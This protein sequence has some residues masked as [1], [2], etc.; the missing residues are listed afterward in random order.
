M[1][2]QLPLNKQALH[3]KGGV[4]IVLDKHKRAPPSFSVLWHISPPP[5]YSC[6]YSHTPTPPPPPFI[7]NQFI[8]LFSPPSNPL[9]INQTQPSQVW[10]FSRS[11]LFAAA[12]R[13]ESMNAR[14]PLINHTRP[15]V[16]L[17]SVTSGVVFRRRRHVSRWDLGGASSIMTLISFFLYTD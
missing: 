14:T 10:P 12:G 1:L 6:C 17:S 8:I 13:R 2:D 7:V 3:T 11:L 5:L 4:E 16:W 9:I 15:F